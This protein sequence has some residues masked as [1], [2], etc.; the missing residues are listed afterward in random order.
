MTPF[1]AKRINSEH[2]TSNESEVSELESRGV[3]IL[4][5]KKKLRINGELLVTR[6][7]GDRKYKDYITNEPEI[8]Q[9]DLKEF[10]V[11]DSA[12]FNENKQMNFL[13]LASD[14][15]WNVFDLKSNLSFAL[16]TSFTRF[17]G[18]FIREG[19]QF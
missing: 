7:F 19:P 11:A 13:V 4:E 16:L 14:G 12:E 17:S 6:S 8:I 1:S 18:K 5:Y 2:N 15:F 9:F 10:L 3:L